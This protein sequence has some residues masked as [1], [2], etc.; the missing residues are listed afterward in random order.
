MDQLPKKEVIE[1]KKSL[2]GLTELLFF[3]DE[4]VDEII[5]LSFYD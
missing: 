5:L 4:E 1:L 3:G 2:L